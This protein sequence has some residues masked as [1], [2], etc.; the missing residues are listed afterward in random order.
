MLELGAGLFIVGAVLVGG[1]LFVILVLVY[2]LR[3]F[4]RKG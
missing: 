3:N 2:S 4:Q 1:G